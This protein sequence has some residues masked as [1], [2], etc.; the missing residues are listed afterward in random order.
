[1]GHSTEEPI[2]AGLIRR[3]DIDISILYGNVDHI[4]TTPYGMLLLELSGDVEKIQ[5]ALS[6]LQEKQLGI[7]V[8]GYVARHDNVAS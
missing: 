2:I 8:I 7:E 3:F 1:M 6:Y 5:E 4:K